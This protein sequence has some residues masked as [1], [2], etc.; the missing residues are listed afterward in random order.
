MDC[1]TSFPLYY[2]KYFFF[3]FRS[4]RY[5]HVNIP[6]NCP[7][8]FSAQRVLRHVSRICAEIHSHAYTVWRTVYPRVYLGILSYTYLKYSTTKTCGV[9]TCWTGVASLQAPTLKITATWSKKILI[10]LAYLQPLKTSATL[11]LILALATTD[12]LNKNMSLCLTQD[13]ANVRTHS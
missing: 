10:A 8:D 1:G 13:E 4:I 11:P 7:A 12:R 3:S 5:K 9:Y 2:T 6:P